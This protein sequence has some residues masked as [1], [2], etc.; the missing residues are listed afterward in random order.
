MS[1]KLP[2]PNAL[3][4]TELTTLRAILTLCPSVCPSLPS[5]KTDI[6]SLL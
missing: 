6:S 5:H 2:Q 1:N 4:P 3:L